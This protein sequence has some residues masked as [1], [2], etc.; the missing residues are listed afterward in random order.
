ISWKLGTS[1]AATL[2]AGA[3]AELPADGGTGAELSGGEAKATPQQANDRLQTRT[4]ECRV[5]GNTGEAA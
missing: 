2:D 1:L 5:M 4:N 3:G